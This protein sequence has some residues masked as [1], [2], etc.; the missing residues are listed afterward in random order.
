MNFEQLSAALAANPAL[1]VFFAAIA[2]IVGLVW[3]GRTRSDTPS[4]DSPMLAEQLENQ[5]RRLRDELARARFE[6]AESAARDRNE[7]SETMG[8][9]NNR[10]LGTLSEISRTQLDQLEKLGGQMDR[11][12]E[13]QERHLRT[14]SETN[15]DQLRELREVV[16]E[17]LQGTLE[18]RL[19]ESFK[20]VSERLQQV[21]EGLG[22]MR[23]LATG[24]GDLKRVLT[25]VK[26][27]GTWG[28]YQLEALLEQLLTPQQYEK[29]VAV[30]PSS[31]ERV[32]F[33]I[34]LPGRDPGGQNTVWLPIDAKYP[35]EDFKRLA[36][37]SEDGDRELVRQ[38]QARL[39]REILKCAQTISDKYIQPPHTTDFA[40]MFLPTEGLYAEVLRDGVLAERLQNEFRVVVAGPT[41]LG[42]LLNSLQMGFRTLTIEQR[43]S[44]VWQT[45][46]EVRSEFTKFGTIIERV[47]KKLASASDEMDRARS[48]TKTIESRLRKVEE[49]PN[50]APP[51]I[52]EPK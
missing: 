6:S 22:E 50:E 41:T 10:I 30:R 2:A 51:R 28:E 20:Q 49:L 24:V 40:V 8:E 3:S 42:A 33:C 16:D 11:A 26:V 23:N 46:A 47:Q 17:K 7:I 44:E 1:L 35:H 38:A 14:L 43:S 36:D 19:A 39:Q 5:E 45:L 25:N 15:A 34:R 31:N 48:K 4:G 32:E 12:A 27:R 21:H 13:R 37:A 52:E 29:N 18:K 9:L